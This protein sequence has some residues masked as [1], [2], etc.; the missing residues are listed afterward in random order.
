M[1]QPSSSG[2][3][4]E[5]YWSP[6]DTA[7]WMTSQL[8]GT[9]RIHWPVVNRRTTKTSPFTS[10]RMSRDWWNHRLRLILPW[11]PFDQPGVQYAG[12]R[13]SV[14]TC[15]PERM[16]STMRKT[17]KKCCQPSQAGSPTGAPSG[18][19]VSPG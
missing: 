13:R 5:R 6:A 18:R 19:G 4:R 3:S 14:R 16:I 1:T 9:T 15:R 11:P 8:V 12:G 17:L 10:H 2:Q 7:F